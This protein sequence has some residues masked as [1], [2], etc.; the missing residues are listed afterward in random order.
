VL[1]DQRLDLF[2]FYVLTLDTL[3]MPSL[4]LVQVDR[5]HLKPTDKI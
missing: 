2:T 5:E 1:R 3:L 4:C